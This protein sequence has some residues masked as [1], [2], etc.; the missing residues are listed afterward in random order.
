MAVM[1]KIYFFKVSR[2]PRFGIGV[3][4]QGELLMRSL[5]KGNKIKIDK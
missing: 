1:T 2:G 4:Q 3:V 5:S